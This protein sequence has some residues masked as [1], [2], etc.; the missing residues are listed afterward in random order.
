[1]NEMEELFGEARRAAD[2]LYQ[3]RDTY[4]PANPA[5][6]ISEL[7]RKSDLALSLLDSLPLGIAFYSTPNIHPF[8]SCNNFSHTLCLVSVKTD[9]NEPHVLWEIK[10]PY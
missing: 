4:F 8:Y 2:D 7:Q 5:E 1:M 3:L 10:I 9:E 6:K